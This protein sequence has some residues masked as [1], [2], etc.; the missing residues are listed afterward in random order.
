MLKVLN[1]NQSIHLSYCEL[2]EISRS[3]FVVVFINSNFLNS[4]L[5]NK[6]IETAKRHLKF[7]QIVFLEDIKESFLCKQFKCYQGLT[8]ESYDLQSKDNFIRNS[9][10]SYKKGTYN[11]DK[12]LFTNQVRTNL[13]MIKRVQNANLFL[14]LSIISNEEII[15]RE[16]NGNIK[17]INFETNKI[18]GY[19]YLDG[20]FNSSHCWLEHCERLFVIDKFVC[21]LFEKNGQIDRII[22]VNALPKNNSLTPLYNQMTKETIITTIYGN[23]TILDREFKLK[24][25]FDLQKQNRIKLE[26]LNENIYLW[27]SYGNF[28]VY[29]FNFYKLVSFLVSDLITTVMYDHQMTS[30]FIL[31]I[32]LL[33]KDVLLFNT[34]TFTIDGFIRANFELSFVLNEN[35]ILNDY[36]GNLLMYKLELKHTENEL[37][38]KYI[39]KINPFDKHLYSNPFLLPCGASGCLDCIYNNM[40]FYV[41]I[42]KCTICHDNHVLNGKLE[43]DFLTNELLKDNCKE[44]L[45]M[46]LNIKKKAIEGKNLFFLKSF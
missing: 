43:K 26:I 39:C 24:R 19:I 2:N 25:V 33:N 41:G 11:L 42:Y 35:L 36:D 38:S 6:T 4:V 34:N 30:N 28:E 27:D 15:V 37:N 14:G 44:I 16:M 46:M 9:L 10:F 45:K 13:S 12:N 23:I 40:N 32:Q 8:I 31:F 20:A 5:L 21:K 3:K 7:I 29:D 18:I 17:I 1:E 22:D